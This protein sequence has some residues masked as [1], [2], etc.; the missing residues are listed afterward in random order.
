MHTLASPEDK[1][2]LLLPLPSRDSAEWRP[3]EAK[4]RQISLTLQDAAM[5]KVAELEG[6]DA[7]KG[8]KLATYGALV[9]R[10]GAVNKAMQP[11]SA[12]STIDSYAKKA[13]T[14][15]SVTSL[16]PVS[17]AAVRASSSSSTAAIRADDVSLGDVTCSYCHMVGHWAK[18]C[19]SK[20]AAAL[21]TSRR[22]PGNKSKS[23]KKVFKK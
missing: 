2:F 18:A 22:S 4:L 15:A 23:S 5:K 11:P 7:A 20:T 1:A 21:P 12:S 14:S 9:K 19:P 8:K 17:S 10:L 13:G 16:L 6:P 3:W